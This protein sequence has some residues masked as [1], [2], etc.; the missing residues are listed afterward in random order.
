MFPRRHT[1]PPFDGHYPDSRSSEYGVETHGRRNGEASP[2]S[3]STVA[4][5]GAAQ[6]PPEQ[7]EETGSPTRTTSTQKSTLLKRN[8]WVSEELEGKDESEYLGQSMDTAKT[9]AIVSAD[10]A[11][12]SMESTESVLA[13]CDP[14]AKTSVPSSPIYVIEQ[15]P[16]VCRSNNST[17]Q[18]PG[19]IPIL[20]SDLPTGAVDTSHLGHVPLPTVPDVEAHLDPHRSLY[21]PP[22]LSQQHPPFPPPVVELTPSIIA[23]VQKHCRFAISSLDYE[24]ADQARKELRAALAIL[25]DT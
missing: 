18:H 17:T 15:Q 22:M 1:P 12:H 11:E 23:K 25:G 9:Q 13:V 6:G 4:T 24:D 8:P 7:W 2:G 19:F 21:P 14:Q 3:W 5:P 20:R 16:L 10:S